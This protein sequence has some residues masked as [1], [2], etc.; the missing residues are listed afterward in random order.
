[1]RE[2]NGRIFWGFHAPLSSLA[3]AGLLVLASSRLAFAIVCAGAL[4]WVYGFTSLV[5]FSSRKIMPQ[6]GKSVI[7]LFLSSFVCGI[8]IL[9]LFLIN[10]L[11]IMG[12]CFFLFLVP[13]CCTGSGLFRRRGFPDLGEAVFRFFFESLVLGGL[14]IAVSLIR[15]P[16]G[17]GS[18]SFPGGVQGMVEI[19]GDEHEGFFPAR[20]FAAS[21]G[22][23]LILGYG[24]ALFRYF[25]SLHYST[26]ENQ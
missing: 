15:E 19:S 21:G 17:L 18:L 11:T 23:L 22:G 20:I 1:M 10:P 24:I 26:E 16:L 6:K 8:Y 7:L 14:I 5:Y 2:Q 9:C 3:G 25:R 4:I 13:P 12:T